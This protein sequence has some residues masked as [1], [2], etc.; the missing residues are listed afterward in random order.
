MSLNWTRY[1]NS[2]YL[3]YIMTWTW[4]NQDADNI[5]K[6]AYDSVKNQNIQLE[7]Y[8]QNLSS[9]YSTDDQMTEYMLAN[10]T[11]YSVV[12]NTLFYVY[13]ALLIVVLYILIFL[14]KME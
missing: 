9:S 3:L 13:Y 4:T 10:I 7:T 1:C 5:A 8:K 11:W 2:I 12:N 6:Q 14:K